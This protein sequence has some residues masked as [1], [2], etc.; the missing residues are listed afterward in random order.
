MGV[1]TVALPGCAV[2]RR[3]DPVAPQDQRPNFVFILIDDLGWND[4]A[5]MGSDF[6]QTPHIDRLARDGVVFTSAYANAPNCAPSR[7]CILSGQYPPRHGVYTVGSSARG[8]AFRRKLI[9]IENT[10][11]LAPDHVTLAEVLHAAGYATGHVGKW[12]LGDDETGPKPQGFDVNVAGNHAGHPKSY[13]SPYQNKD[14]ADG[15]QGEY[16]TDRLTD[17]ALRFIEANRSRPFFLYLS[18]YA[19]HTPI[20]AKSDV[21]AKYKRIQDANRATGTNTRHQHARYAAMI[22]SVDDSIGRV[23]RQLDELQLADNTVV[24]FFSDNGGHGGVTNQRPLRGAKGMLYEGGVREPMIIR[25]PRM[26]QSGRRCDVPVIGIDL[27]PTLLEIAGV[28]KPPEKLLDGVS[29]VPLMRGKASLPHRALFWHF[30]CYL[31]G[32]HPDSHDRGWRTTPCGAVREGDWKLIEYFEG[33]ELELYNLANDI[34]ERNNL[35]AKRPEKARELHAL[36][37]NWR[38]QVQ[39]PVPVKRNPLYKPESEG[40]P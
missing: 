13:F 12:H 16:L 15:P 1:A 25:W 24:I 17:E 23:L 36:L 39:A 28:A 4:P 40:T 3:S 33:G 7:A 29:L 38:R 37:R 2:L 11:A 27:F 6:H 22:E 5:F 21:V 14:L 32:D 31:Q 10:A 20:Q 9:P 19:V 30:P 34:G 35:A 18:H 26:T 8:S